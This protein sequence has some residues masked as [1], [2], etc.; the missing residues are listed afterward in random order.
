MTK[1]IILSS[2]GTGGHVFPALSLAQTLH[3]RGYK[4]VIMTDHRGQVFQQAAGVS[5]V[6]ALP[7]WK[8]RGLLAPLVLGA[9]LALSF[10]LAIVHMIRL[11]PSAV[12][13]F[14][15]Y[16]SLPAVLAGYVMRLPTALHEQ[17]A[18]LGRANRLVARFVKRIGVAFVHVK[19][20][21]AFQDKLVYTG[22]PVRQSIQAIRDHAY[23]PSNGQEPF[24]LLIIGGS[25]GARIFSDVIPKALCDL[26]PNLRGRLVIWQQCRPEFL[27]MTKAAYEKSE[28]SVELKPFFEDVDQR[29]RAAHL[30]IARAGASTMAELGVSGRPALLVP[31][32]YA[33]DNHQQAN[34]MSLSDSGAAWVVLEKGFTSQ[35]LQELLVSAMTDPKGL[36]VMADKMHHFGQPDA[37]LKLAQMVEGLF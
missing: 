33:M 20:A 29:M 1:T 2:G 15:G 30:I 23:E 36:K 13:G 37:A 16:P 18:V 27:E 10:F 25:Q 14:G 3:E 17:N 22:N 24:R 6:I 9:G 26:S 8:G 11:R 7:A 12:L 28:I 34:A 5:K 21:D 32:P 31:Y 4:V 35:K 19:F